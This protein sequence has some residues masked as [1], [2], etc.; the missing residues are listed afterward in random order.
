MRMKTAKL[1]GG[2]VLVLASAAR[3]QEPPPP[4][5]PPSLPPLEFAP[6]TDITGV[7]LSRLLEGDSA[8][9]GLGSF[10][11]HLPK[12]GISTYIH[13]I[14]ELAG[15][16]QSQSAPTNDYHDLSGT[17]FS[18]DSTFELFVGAK[19][20][21]RV[22]VEMQ[23]AFSQNKSE[24]VYTQID[25]RLFR[26]L[27]YVRGGAFLMPVGGLNV[28]PDSLY[29]FKLPEHPMMYGQILP[30]E[31]TDIGIEV[32]GVYSWREGRSLRYAAYVVNGLEQ[33]D[34]GEGGPINAM[35][36]NFTEAFDSSKSYGGQIQLTPV[37]GFSIAG[38]AYRGVYTQ[39]G[40]RNLTIAD[41]HL[42]LRRWGVTAM[43][44]GAIALQDITAARLTKIGAFAMV[45]YRAHAYVE[46]V[47]MGEWFTLGQGKNVDRFGA[48]AGIIVY[49]FPH[50][51]RSA[52]LRFSYGV[53]WDGARQFAGH[54]VSG[55]LTVAF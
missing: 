55:L 13:G 50:K 20:R 10:E 25:L 28:Y 5:P 41:L 53:T 24:M 8:L 31:W 40:L 1:I 37:P 34:A 46:P 14:A 27:I 7:P 3:G 2:L 49:P 54:R 11:L 52:Q 17:P 23:A 26:D 9:S 6:T 22:F 29:V 4:A 16:W 38:S 43:A 42:E 35:A 21:D 45:S 51:V 19:I 48:T 30:R 39:N 32:H 12:Y 44:E 15:A 33:R 47:A 36:G 18:F